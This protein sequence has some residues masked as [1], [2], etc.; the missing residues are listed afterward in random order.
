MTGTVVPV[1][2]CRT[3]IAYRKLYHRERTKCLYQ[4]SATLLSKRSTSPPPRN[5]P[6]LYCHTWPDTNRFLPCPPFTWQQF[7][8][9]QLFSSP[10]PQHPTP[11]FSM[12]S[13]GSLSAYVGK[14]EDCLKKQTDA[15][16]KR[17]LITAFRNPWLLRKWCSRLKS[18]QRFQVAGHLSEH[19]S[20]VQA[21]HEQ[22]A[23]KR[24]S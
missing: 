8:R 24:N 16:T 15:E 23:Y 19:N 17:V 12:T 3:E 1:G 11:H 4:P 22:P 20:T 18:F 9:D 2:S 21:C 7:Y 10:F 6:G 5:E 14:M 13:S